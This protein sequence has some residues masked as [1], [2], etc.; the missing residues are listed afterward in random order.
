MSARTNLHRWALPL[1][2]TNDGGIGIQPRYLGYA[3]G[4][5][6]PATS[7]GTNWKFCFSM[8]GRC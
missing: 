7:G 2:T 8:R 4:D 5:G 3:D 1:H 6:R